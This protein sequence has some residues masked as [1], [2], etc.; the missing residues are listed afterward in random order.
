MPVN[1]ESTRKA[2]IYQFLVYYEYLNIRTSIY[3][4]FFWFINGVKKYFI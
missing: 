3:F 2:G 1:T 4:L